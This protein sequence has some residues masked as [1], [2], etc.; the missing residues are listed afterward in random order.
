ME[1]CGVEYK[2]YE[3]L[4]ACIRPLGHHGGHSAFT[5]VVPEP[6]VVPNVHAADCCK[7]AADHIREAVAILLAANIESSEV[8]L[9]KT[10]LAGL[11][12]RVEGLVK[13]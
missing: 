5:V 12:I 4:K 9:L 8:L 3:G 2:T 6:I 13:L 1:A 7:S 11:I 10:E